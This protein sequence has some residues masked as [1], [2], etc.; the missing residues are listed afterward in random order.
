MTGDGNNS[1]TDGLTAGDLVTP[2]ADRCMPIEL[3]LPRLPPFTTPC[4]AGRVRSNGTGFEAA[5]GGLFRGGT[6]GGSLGR[7]VLVAGG[8]AA[9][10]VLLSV[11]APVIV[12]VFSHCLR[13][14]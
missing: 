5:E 3:F 8:V 1:A 11:A 12:G 4:L 2:V 10:D 6:T 14:R 13:R 9:L 7:S